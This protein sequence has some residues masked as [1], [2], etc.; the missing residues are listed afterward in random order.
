MKKS[1]LILF[2]CCI[3]CSC[4]Y[5]DKYQ[6]EV[7]AIV[8]FT[9]YASLSGEMFYKGVQMA[10]N[11]INSEDS[12]KIKFYYEDCKSSPKDALT[13]YRKLE[14]KGLKYFVGFGGQFV[15][16]FASQTKNTNKVLFASGAANDNLMS[17]TN[18]CLR[19]YPTIEVF[20]DKVRGFVVS[21]NYTNIAIIYMQ[22]EAYSKY[23]EVARQK[24]IKSDKK[25]VLMESYNP[26]NRDFRDIL[27][28]IVQNNVDL[29]YFS[30][31][32][33]GVAIFTKQLFDNPQTNNIPIIGDM[34]FSDGNNLEAIGEIKAPINAIDSYI[35]SSFINKF[36]S[37]YNQKPNAYSVYGY[38]IPFVLKETIETLGDNCTTNEVYEYIR[39]CQLNTI[40]GPISFNPETSEPNMEL[41]IYT[42]GPTYNQPN[43]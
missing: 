26:N 15:L 34:N 18:R 10:V 16:G 23:A 3:I 29:I 20:T 32:G 28:K 6:I 41:T 5:T 33:D 40:A 37:L 22:N 8:P 27:N 13:A 14:S 11:E 9:G 36:E 38:I 4:G 42:F 31:L 21:G 35:D 17:L 7:G 30:G 2:T 1:L 39:S 25:I 12:N 43:K 24:L 19:F